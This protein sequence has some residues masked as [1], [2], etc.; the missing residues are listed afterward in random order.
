MNDGPVFL[1]R[2]TVLHIHKRA[3]E[4]FGG[5][6]GLRDEG[7]FESA[8]LAAENRYFYEDASLAECAA[9]Y[10]FHLC[11]AH[12]FVDGNKR[13]AAMAAETFLRLNGVTLAATN[14]ELIDLFLRIASG[15][16]PRSSVDRFFRKRTRIG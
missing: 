9:A 4:T 2:D 14:E 13:V 6:H 8:L 5:S 12:A 7:A 3:I 11:Q 15:G 1:L 10:A 16:V